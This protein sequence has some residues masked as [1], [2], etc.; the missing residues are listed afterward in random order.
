MSILVTGGAGYIGAHIVD[1]LRG[2]GDDVVIIDDLATGIRSRVADVPVHV[3][4]LAGD[5]AQALIEK[6]C[7][8]S[9]KSPQ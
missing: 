4:D 6:P 3:F 2:R 7:S 5:G 9:M 1:L 8:L